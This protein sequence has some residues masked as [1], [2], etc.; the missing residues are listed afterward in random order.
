M[1]GAKAAERD[2]NNREQAMH[3]EGYQQTAEAITLSI[4]SETI[5][6]IGPIS[7]SPPPPPPPPYPPPT[8]NR[9]F[10]APPHNASSAAAVTTIYRSFQALPGGEE[11]KEEEEAVDE[12]FMTPTINGASGNDA[13]K[14]WP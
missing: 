8:S 1:T 11:E 10:N 6:F 7:L 9:A 12:A 13:I 5:P 14:S 2:A 4:S 3:R